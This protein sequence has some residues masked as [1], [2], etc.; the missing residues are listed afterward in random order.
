MH[1]I[2]IL[3]GTFDPVHLG[4]IQTSIAIQSYFKFDSFYF[5]P[6]KIPAIKPPALANNTQRIQMLDLAIKNHPEFKIDL[7]EVNRDSPSYMVETLQSF[8]M[9]HSNSSINLIMGYDAFLTLAQWHQWQKITEL[10]NLL[11]INRSHYANNPIPDEVKKLIE[12]HAKDSA[13]LLKKK[14][15]G[16][17]CF[18]NA[19][20]YVISSTELRKKLRQHEEVINELPKEVD[21]YIKRWKLYQ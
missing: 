19:G 1:S 14:K 9:E 13:T 17:I 18:F 6:C 11:V 20:N 10:A 16:I 2:A 8:R 15:A 5:L 4:H 7:R 3:G 21:E 12:L